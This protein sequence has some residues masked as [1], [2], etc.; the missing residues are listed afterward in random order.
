MAKRN[1]SKLLASRAKS[2][3]KNNVTLKSVLPVKSKMPTTSLYG[4]S[5]KP[6]ETVELSSGDKIPKK[7]IDDINWQIRRHNERAWQEVARIDKIKADGYNT[8]TDFRK[9]RGKYDGN[10]KYVRSHRDEHGFLIPLSTNY[11]TVGSA[12]A[13]MRRLKELKKQNR[14]N[15]SYYRNA[16][17]NSMTKILNAMGRSDLSK[18]IKTMNNNAFDVLNTRTDIWEYLNIMYDPDNSNGINEWMSE[19]D[20]SRFSG[21]IDK[22]ISKIRKSVK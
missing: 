3:N 15:Y 8:L 7:L 4:M 21:Y 18:K 13:A 5:F 20:I 11:N 19:S 17:K 6:K 12:Q 9:M 2:Y 10:G 14:K 1:S 16:N 22:H